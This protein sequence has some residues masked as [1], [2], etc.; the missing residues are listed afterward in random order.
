MILELIKFLALN[1]VFQT[2]KVIVFEN[3]LI[4]SPLLLSN[5]IR[6]YWYL[7]ESIHRY[8]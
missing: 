2:Q 4:I 6:K 3:I 1:S 5:R 7:H 8:Q